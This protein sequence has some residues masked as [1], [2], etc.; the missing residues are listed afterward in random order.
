[1]IHTRAQRLR[2]NPAFPAPSRRAPP[3]RQ[4]GLT[5]CA[6][7]NCPNGLVSLRRARLKLRSPEKLVYS[8]MRHA[9]HIADH[10]LGKARVSQLP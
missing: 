1:M 3:F 9:K 5:V 4:T 10:R 6:T 2:R 8:L 7:I